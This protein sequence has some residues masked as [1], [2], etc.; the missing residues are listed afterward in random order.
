MNADPKREVQV[1][2]GVACLA[3]GAADRGD[4]ESSEDLEVDVGL[5]DSQIALE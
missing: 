1:G 5:R 3:T 2:M 4:S